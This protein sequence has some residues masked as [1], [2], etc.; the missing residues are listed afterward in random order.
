VLVAVNLGAVTP[1][2][3]QYVKGEGKVDPEFKSHAMKM[4]P[5]D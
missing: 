1:L 4:Y 2:V 3:L 5:I